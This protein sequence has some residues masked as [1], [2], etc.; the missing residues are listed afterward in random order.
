MHPRKMVCKLITE[1]MHDRHELM[2]GA[3]A[4]SVQ[5]ATGGLEGPAAAAFRSRR[6][7]SF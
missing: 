3:A 5:G 7:R 2:S 1:P 4:P 6:S